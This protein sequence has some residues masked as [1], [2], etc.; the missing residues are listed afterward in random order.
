V[1]R[2]EGRRGV[3][4]DAELDRLRGRV[5]GERGDDAQPEI[6]ARGD[7]ARGDHV[8]VADDPGLLVRRPDERQEVGVGPMRRRPPA[9]EQPGG[10]EDEGAGADGGDV[11][12][13]R[14]LGAHERDRLRI[15]DGLD[16]AGRAAGDA[17]EVERRTVGEGAGRDEAEPAIARHRRHRL[18]DDAGRRLRQPRQDL[19]RPGEVELRQVGEDDEADG[20]AWQGQSR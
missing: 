16:D 12:G 5:A 18:R 8:A 1:A 4:L 9:V 20:E 10:A 11:F 14:R 17:E 7:A 2:I 19:E 13:V 15:G 6:D 3:V